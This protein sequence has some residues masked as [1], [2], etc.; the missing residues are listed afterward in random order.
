MLGF[1]SEDGARFADI[2]HGADAEEACQHPDAGIVYWRRA[3]NQPVKFVACRAGEATI[4]VWHETEAERLST[5]EF[6][7]RPADGAPGTP[8]VLVST[9]A[10]AVDEG[11]SGIYTVE[12]ASQPTGD[13]T[14]TPSVTGNVDV[15]VSEALT[16][17]PSNW[18]TAQTVTVSAADDADTA[19][20]TATVSHAVAGA[21]YGSV[22]AASVAVTG[23]RPPR[24]CR[25]GEAAWNATL[26]RASAGGRSRRWPVPTCS[27]S[28]PPSGTPSRSWPRPSS[29]GST[30]CWSGPSP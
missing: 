10:L 21:N 13:V 2:T 6:R 12:L 9:T 4:E 30:P 18:D 19:D 25:R 14:V 17:T 16:F 1:G 5:Y 28:S 8:G 23:G 26:S 20:D 24:R 15:T 11:G 29:S 27:R 7:I 22:T 3:I